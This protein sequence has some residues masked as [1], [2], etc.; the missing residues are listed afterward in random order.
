LSGVCAAWCVLQELAK[1]GSSIAAEITELKSSAQAAAAQRDAT[2]AEL[3]DA[4]VQ[5]AKELKRLRAEPA[6]A[7]AS[8]KPGVD[9]GPDPASVAADTAAEAQANEESA[10]AAAEAESKLSKSVT[11]VAHLK[12]AVAA[13]ASEMDTM[14]TRLKKLMGARKKESKELGEVRE[15]LAHTREQLQ[16]TMVQNQDLKKKLEATAA[17]TAEAKV[18][19]RTSDSRSAGADE[20]AGATATAAVGGD[21]SGF[22]GAL[23]DLET[24]AIRGQ[25]PTLNISRGSDLPPELDMDSQPVDLSADLAALEAA[26]AAEGE[27]AV[28]P[29]SLGDSVFGGI[30]PADLEVDASMVFPGNGASP[31]KAAATVAAAATTE[32]EKHSSSVGDDLDAGFIGDGEIVIEE[33][34]EEAGADADSAAMD[35]V[36]ALAAPPCLSNRSPPAVRSWCDCLPPT[37]RRRRFV[38]R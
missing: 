16:Q 24:A 1:L 4:H 36:R 17:A 25:A 26:A 19:G 7:A 13:A 6:A 23:K 35:E 20:A 9:V 27:G 3:L 5:H 33:N 2:A 10:A 22:T 29:E 21:L 31:I 15:A 28:G 18:T 11:E 34:E 32:A 14:K 38:A 8:T 12:S 30:G 37:P